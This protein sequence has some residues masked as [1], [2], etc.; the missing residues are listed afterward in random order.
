MDSYQE[1]LPRFNKTL[2]TEP[3]YFNYLSAL[4]VTLP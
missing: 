4:R 1:L 2:T 3:D